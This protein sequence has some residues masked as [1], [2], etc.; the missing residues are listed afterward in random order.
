M[1]S[2]GNPVKDRELCHEVLTK[3]P[4]VLHE[5][6]TLS[7]LEKKKQHY[8]GTMALERADGLRAM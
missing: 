5:F 4:T 7:G 3:F 8:S 2:G 1:V 6:T